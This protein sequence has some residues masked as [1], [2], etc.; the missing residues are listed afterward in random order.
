MVCMVGKGGKHTQ[1]VNYNNLKHQ[2]QGSSEIHV[3]LKG[4]ISTRKC[5]RSM[6]MDLTKSPEVFLLLFV[7][8]QG[9]K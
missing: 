5:N 2:L 6:Y 9:C 3:S 7:R 8:S 1:E 4:K